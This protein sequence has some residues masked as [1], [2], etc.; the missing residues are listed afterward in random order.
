MP[1][2]LIRN[3][4]IRSF[5]LFVALLAS[6]VSGRAEAVLVEVLAADNAS[7]AA[8]DDGWSPGD[9]GGFGLGGWSTIDNAVSPTG[10]GGGF[11]GGSAGGDID[12]SG[13][14]FGVFGNNGGVGQ[15]IRSLGGDLLAGQTFAI[16]MDNGL[17][18]NGG[19]VGFGLQNAAGQ[20]LV[21]FFFVGGMS[22]YAVNAS[23]VTGTT[24]SFTTAGLALS[25]TLTDS[26]SFSLE[27]DDL[28]SG[29]GVDHT[30]IGD[31][32]ASTDQGIE[33]LRL[34]NANGGANIYFNSLAITAVPEVSPAM[35]MPLLAMA[36]YAIRSRRRSSRR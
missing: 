9:N 30:V 2:T 1:P 4:M 26:D 33:Q 17:V 3:V 29:P 8:Y 11:I 31:L 23:G 13:E 27:I 6:L 5:S 28:G 36:G 18:D 22:N 24:P 35:V 19:T 14:S 34:F 7:D 25:L 16:S 20:N 32:L 12:V 21:E 10:F 15:A